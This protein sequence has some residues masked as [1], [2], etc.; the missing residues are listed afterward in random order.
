MITKKDYLI[1]AA[2]GFLTGVFGLVV[3]F[4]LEINFLFKIPLV[5]FGVPVL[6][7][8]GVWLGG[9]LGK[10]IAPFFTQFG[11]FA[12]VGFSSASMDFAILNFMSYAT[13]IT[14]GV[15]VG[16]VNIP[17]FLVAVLNGYLWNRLWVF[18]VE[19][20]LNFVDE[21]SRRGWSSSRTP[22][23][24]SVFVRRADSRVKEF[25]DTKFGLFHDF[26]KFFGVTVIGLLINSGI[27]ILLTTYFSAPALDE[28]IWLNIAKVI[29]NAVALMWNFIGYKFIAFK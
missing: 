23:N 25:S 17:G 5:I 9:F 26:P 4:F 22:R 1:A 16:W 27:I 7:V 21:N 13:G 12:A 6:W 18:S 11:K 2:N 15:I 24:S 14:A 10:R 28:K 29:A 8:L 20:R 3:L 19:K